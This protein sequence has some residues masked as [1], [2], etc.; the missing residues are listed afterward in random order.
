M[1]KTVNGNPRLSGHLLLFKN[2]LYVEEGDSPVQAV[3]V[4]DFRNPHQCRKIVE[5]VVYEQEEPKVYF[6]SSFSVT[7]Y[8][9]SQSSKHI[10]FVIV[11]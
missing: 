8:F 5:S 1:T 11:W 6:N 2:C 9:M 10:G 4:E 7:W 3:Y